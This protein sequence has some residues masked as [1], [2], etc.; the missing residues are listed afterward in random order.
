MAPKSAPKRYPPANSY[1]CPSTPLVCSTCY[2]PLPSAN[3]LSTACLL[4]LTNRRQPDM[5]RKGRSWRHS[6][7]NTTKYKTRKR[8][9]SIFFSSSTADTTQA[10]ANPLLLTSPW[11]LANSA[12]RSSRLLEGLVLLRL[13]LVS[14]W[15][16]LLLFLWLLVLCCGCRVFLLL[17]LLAFLGR[18]LLLVHHHV[19][20]VVVL[21]PLGAG[22]AA[23]VGAA[24]PA[25]AAA[26]AA[27]AKEGERASFRSPAMAR[28][29]RHRHLS[30]EDEC[31]DGCKNMDPTCA[32]Y[33]TFCQWS[34]ENGVRDITVCDT[35]DQLLVDRGIRSCQYGP[36]MTYNVFKY[37]ER[38]CSCETSDEGTVDCT[39]T[40]TMSDGGEH[41]DAAG[42]EG[43]EVNWSSCNEEEH[44]PPASTL[45]GG[46]LSGN[47][48]ASELANAGHS[49][50]TRVLRDTVLGGAVVGPGGMFTL[51]QEVTSGVILDAEVYGGEFVLDGT[52]GVTEVVFVQ[53]VTDPTSTITFNAGAVVVMGGSNAGTLLGLNAQDS[54]KLTALTNTGIVRMENNMPGILI[55]D[56]VNEPSGEVTLIECKAS[57]HGVVNKGTVNLSGGEYSYKGGTNEGV[58]N[59]EGD[60]VSATYKADNAG[61]IN[62][63]KGVATAT[64]G[65]NTGTINISDGVTGE[66]IVETKNSAGNWGTIMYKGAVVTAD[67]N[68][69][70]VYIARHA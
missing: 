27:L 36:A 70:K 60:G 11:A 47:S 4:F 45:Y 3:L 49:A 35:P 52:S 68:D 18:L 43:C 48:F 63:F 25:P 1:A 12:A 28:S 39:D 32:K 57:V 14:L 58:I 38:L 34:D 2:P 50:D 23:G 16:L 41:C 55:T 64:F 40:F 67:I 15:L 19:F 59:M 29:S 9:A 13:L 44:N 69:G 42:M 51:P 8:A 66:F 62:V 26:A 65:T 53:V 46:F 37:E 33:A 54:V 20:V 5:K 24:A 22:P 21:F 56:T 30:A 17:G 7:L 61:T 31:D 6:Q 10:A